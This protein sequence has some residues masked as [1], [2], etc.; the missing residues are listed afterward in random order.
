MAI[1]ITTATRIFRIE[2]GGA[3]LSDPDPAMPLEEVMS[4]YCPQY[5]ELTTATIHGPAFEEDRVVYTIKTTI[6]IKG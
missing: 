4:F 3:E 6:G 1:N 2:K 5:P